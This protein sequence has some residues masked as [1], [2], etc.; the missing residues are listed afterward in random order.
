MIGS[1]YVI[2]CLYVHDMLIFGTNLSIIDK[3]KRLLSS[4]FEMKDLR[5]AYVILGMKLRKTKSFF[6]LSQSYCIEKMLKR[7]NSFDVVPVRTP[8]DSS[9]HLKKNR[10]PSVSQ[11]E[12]AKIMGSLMFLMNYTHPDIAYAVSRLSRYT[13]NPAKEHWDAVYCLLR[14]L[15]GT[16]DWCL[17]FSKFPTV[18]EGFCDANWVTDNDVV[19]S[20]SG[21]VFKLGG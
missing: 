2:I 10:G 21:Y 17:H 14:Y 13:H 3:A 20:T 1:D 18:L 12:Y 4:L 8:Y 6:S 5:E 19:S 11:V 15:R 9:I 16:M 7:F